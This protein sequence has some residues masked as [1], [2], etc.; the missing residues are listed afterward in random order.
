MSGFHEP[1][2]L[3]VGVG[4]FNILADCYALGEFATW[5]GDDGLVW[6]HRREKIAEII[7]RMLQDF[8][9]VVTQ[10]NDHFFDILNLL[11]SYDDSVDGLF[12]VRAD[13]GCTFGSLQQDKCDRSAEQESVPFNYRSFFQAPQSSGT[14]GTS[15]DDEQSYYSHYGIGIYY[16]SSVIQRQ[17]ILLGPGQ[18]LL[19]G[20]RI[21]DPAVVLFPAGKGTVSFLAATFSKRQSHKSP[22][23]SSEYAGPF[24]VVGAHLASGVSR[25]QED[26]RC[27]QAAHIWAAVAAARSSRPQPIIWAMDSNTCNEYLSIMADAPHTESSPSNSNCQRQATDLLGLSGFLSSHGLLSLVPEEDCRFQCFKMRHCRGNQPQKFAELMLCCIDKVC[28][29]LPGG[30]KFGTAAPLSL[31]G[32][33]DLGSTDQT[34]PSS[35]DPGYANEDTKTKAKSPPPPLSP[36][37]VLTVQRLRRDPDQHRRL[38]KL[39]F[40]LP[41]ENVEKEETAPRSVRETGERDCKEK[42]YVSSEILDPLFFTKEDDPATVLA[43]FP[44]AFGSKLK[45][46]FAMLP[47]S[48]QRELAPLQR[49]MPTCANPSD[50]P[51]IG[52]QFTLAKMH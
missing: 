6:P 10:E 12:G 45:E 11:R 47:E 35:S 7:H 42:S 24:T 39:F 49:L 28:L 1:S 23:T 5:D 30:W 34:T 32:S 40:G 17:E 18:K 19:K 41:W 29:W 33:T 37:E 44:N 25:V 48:L 38:R 14:S 2:T 22:Y 31:L 50:H 26:K 8:D 43:R 46:H 20:G 36:E 4:T 27:A 15:N 51:P 16:H 3:N 21:L 52:V 13:S 9:V